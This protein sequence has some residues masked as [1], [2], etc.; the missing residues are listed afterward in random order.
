MLG[1]SIAAGTIVG[2]SLLAAVAVFLTK[3]NTALRVTLGTAITALVVSSVLAIIASVDPPN[4]NTN[5]SKKDTRGGPATQQRVRFEFEDTPESRVFNSV[6][7]S[8]GGLGHNLKDARKLILR[9]V[10]DALRRVE[11]EP[12]EKE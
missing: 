6:R 9:D 2:G 8:I 1:Y 5:N 12:P 3:S 7:R 10:G 4:P 11:M